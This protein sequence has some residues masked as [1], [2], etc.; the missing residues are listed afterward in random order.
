MK[1]GVMD[2]K[3]LSEWSSRL[4]MCRKCMLEDMEN[5]TDIA[6]LLQRLTASIPTNERSDVEEINRRLDICRH[7]DHLYSGTC[8]LCGCFVQLRASKKRAACPDIPDRWR[9]S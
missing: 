9:A 4:P 8:A 3:E 5:G 2:L 6:A 1:D 7:C